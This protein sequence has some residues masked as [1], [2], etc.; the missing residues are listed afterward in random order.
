MLMLVISWFRS[1]IT[2]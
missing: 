1:S 2:W